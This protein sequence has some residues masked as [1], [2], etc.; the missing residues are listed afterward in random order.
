MVT[1]YTRLVRGVWVDLSKWLTGLSE[2]P[3][4]LSTEGLGQLKLLIKK[5]HFLFLV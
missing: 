2:P 4:K 5:V 3:C 1:I